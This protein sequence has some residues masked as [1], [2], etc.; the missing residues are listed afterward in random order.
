MAFVLV[1]FGISNGLER[2]VQSFFTVLFRLRTIC[3]K[4]LENRSFRSPLLR[5]GDGRTVDAADG[6]DKIGLK[7]GYACE[8]AL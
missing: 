8:W 4:T 6:K 3:G 5:R 2:T 7:N 1:L